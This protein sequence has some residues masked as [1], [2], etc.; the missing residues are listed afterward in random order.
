[1]GIFT[2]IVL[3][4]LIK[5]EEKTS[6]FCVILSHPIQVQGM[7]LYLLETTS[8]SS[9]V[10]RSFPHLGSACF[11]LGLCRSIFFAAIVS[12]NRSY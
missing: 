4:S 7:S 9:E 11:L 2:G 6:L 3:K 8:M 12:S 1:M 5:W 10:I